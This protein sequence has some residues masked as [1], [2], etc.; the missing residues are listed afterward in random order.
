[1]EFTIELIV[2]RNLVTISNFVEFRESKFYVFRGN[3]GSARH[4]THF[5]WL[6]RCHVSCAELV[7]HELK[8]GP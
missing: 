7:K 2:S 3:E 8:C 4:L 5:E 6:K 1:M